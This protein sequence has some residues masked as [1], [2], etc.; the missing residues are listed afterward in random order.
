MPK[1]YSTALRREPLT[2]K[3]DLFRSRPRSNYLQLASHG[4]RRLS[5]DERGL[6]AGSPVRAR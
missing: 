4:G 6:T 2:G 5:A 1:N 3:I